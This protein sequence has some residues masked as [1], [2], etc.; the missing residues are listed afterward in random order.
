MKNKEVYR[1]NLKNRIYDKEALRNFRPE[2]ETIVR[3]QGSSE[4]GNFE[5]KPT[6]SETD[7]SCCFGIYWTICPKCYGRGKK[8]FRLRKKSRLRFQIAINEF[9]KTLKEGKASVRPK[10]TQ[11]LCDN[12]S[13]SGLIPATSHPIQSATY[14]P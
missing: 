4:D 3:E 11:F 7:C 5:A 6:R 10:V 2:R 14:A 1:N 13:G 8:N 9:E 12:C